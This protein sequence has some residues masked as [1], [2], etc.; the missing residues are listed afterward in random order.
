MAAADAATPTKEWKAA[1]VCGSDVG[2]TLSPIYFPAAP[3]IP[4]N[5]A[6]LAVVTKSGCRC[7]LK[8]Q[9]KTSEKHAIY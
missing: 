6:I 3:P 4:I 1:T 2:S 9:N 7:P 5:V 8:M